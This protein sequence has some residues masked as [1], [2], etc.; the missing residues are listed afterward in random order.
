MLS[1]KEVDL[2]Y[3]NDGNFKMLLSKIILTAVFDIIPVNFEDK[4]GI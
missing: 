4:N 1:E 2:R 3:Q